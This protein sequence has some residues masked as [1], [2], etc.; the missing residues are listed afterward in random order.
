MGPWWGGLGGAQG[1]R[2][3]SLLVPRLFFQHFSGSSYLVEN[4]DG[5]LV[6]FLIGLLSQTHQDESY[7]HFVGVDPAV[8]GSGLGRYLYRRFFEH[9]RERGRTTVRC[10]TSPGNTGSQAFH[11]RMGFTATL[12]ADYDSPGI[13]RVV[14]AKDLRR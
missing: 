2:E 11:A 10:V 14:F 5:D 3:R 7:I 1:A 4:A 13:D 6:A 9:S 8:R 12:V